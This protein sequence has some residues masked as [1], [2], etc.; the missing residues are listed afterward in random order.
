M[1]VVNAR[2]VSPLDIQN[3]D[4]MMYII[5]AMV[6]KGRK[7]LLYRLYICPLDDEENRVEGIPQG[8]RIYDSD[9]AICRAIFP[10]LACVSEED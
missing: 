5:K 10:S 2:T 3:G 7:G 1:K 6:F 9:K 4:I 8:A